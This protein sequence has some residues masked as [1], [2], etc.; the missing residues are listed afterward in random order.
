MTHPAVTCHV[1]DSLST[2]AKKMWDRDIGAL[3]VVDDRGN[4]AG[5]ITDRDICMAAWTQGRTLGEARVGSA[6]ARHVI[7]AGPD[8]R[9]V[10]L[11]LLMSKHQLHRIPIVDAAGRPLGVVSL[12]DLALE[13]VRPKTAMHHGPSQ[14]VHTL[15][16]IARPRTSEQKAA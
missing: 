8:S 3:V 9:C 15:A 10:D 2:A 13:S 12:N 7:V 6:M 4:L 11:E 1:D 14:V 16:A 5:M